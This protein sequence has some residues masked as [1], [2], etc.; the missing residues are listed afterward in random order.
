M[1]AEILSKLTDYTLE[2][3]KH[4]EEYMKMLNYPKYK[5]HK[6]DHKEFILQVATFNTNLLSA[7]PPKPEEILIFVKNWW[8]NHILKVDIEYE[9]WRKN[10]K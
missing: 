9:E 4:E 3:F 2:H 1:F 6:K 7:T 5:E 8:I 10:N